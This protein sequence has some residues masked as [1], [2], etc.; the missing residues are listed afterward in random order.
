MTISPVA[1]GVARKIMDFSGVNSHVWLDDNHLI[2]LSYRDDQVYRYAV[3]SEE[4]EQLFPVNDRNF[5][6]PELI[7]GT[8]WVIAT[9]NIDGSSDRPGN[10]GLFLF[11]LK[12]GERQLLMENAYHARSIAPGRLVF[13]RENHLWS[14]KFDKDTR[15]PVGNPVRVVSDIENE[16]DFDFASYAISSRGMLA[17]LP[18]GNVSTLQH[19][20]LIWR[21]ANGEEDPLDIEPAYI[22]DIALS[23]D[24][25]KIALS[26]HDGES[27]DGNDIDIWTHDINLPGIV[28]RLTTFSNA[29]NP[30]WSLDQQSVLF[31]RRG[32]DPATFGVWE[33]SAS[34]VGTAERYIP[35]EFYM[36]PRQIT[37][38]N[39][40]VL[41]NPTRRNVF[42]LNDIY[43]VDL[44][45]DANVASALIASEFGE[46]SPNISPDGRLIAYV[47]N[48]TGNQE[49]YVRPFPD[50]DSNKWRVSTNGGRQPRWGNDN[51]LY[52]LVNNSPTSLVT[53]QI[54][55]E[56][57]FRIR[58]RKREVLENYQLFSEPAYAV[59]RNNNRLLFMKFITPVGSGWG[60]GEQPVIANL[61]TNFAEQVERAL[62]E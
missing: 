19:S 33:V 20:Q 62:G 43:I 39:Q 31:D 9:A 41:Q 40:L 24:G 42:S 26:M 6:S 36:F 57:E 32:N 47:S 59:D 2:F 54:D 1:G 53:L 61:V 44:N 11:D 14:A 3:D 4:V 45:N 49:V 25:Q 16:S 10:P 18:G 50:V 28:N 17:Y 55:Y 30:V 29:Q 12:T 22:E 58:D 27:I 46:G 38:T 34:G 7:P 5:Q 52:Y 15:Q 48:E 8:D 56:Q 13:M 21:D 60:D 35:G 23:P 37:A 51:V